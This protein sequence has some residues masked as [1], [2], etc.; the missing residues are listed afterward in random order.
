MGRSISPKRADGIRRAVAAA[1]SIAGTL[2]ELGLYVG[3]SNY[4]TI[5]R[6]VVA[7]G[8]DTSHWTGQG[9]R[10]GSNTP[11]FIARPL[12]EILVKGTAPNTSKLRLRLIAERV[13]VAQCSCCSLISWLGQ[14]IP[15]ELD[16]RDGDRTN[17][18]LENLRLLC[19][20]CHA[21]TPTYRGK[22]IRLRRQVSSAQARV[23]KLVDTGDL[24]K[25]SARLETGAM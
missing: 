1:K 13:L 12:S 10:R 7:L 4:E 24:D 3:G 11:L 16:H 22:N 15:L 2:R 6:A 5:R 23:V 19:P 9:H 20:N 25:L 18:V 14:P 21:L 17:N 8:L